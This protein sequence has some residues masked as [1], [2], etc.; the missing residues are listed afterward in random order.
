MLLKKGEV[1][2]V[3]SGIFESYSREGPFVATQD[4]DLDTFVA[5]AVSAVT[6]AWE[7]TGVLWEVPRMLVVQGFL[8]ELPCRRIHLGALGDVELTEGKKDL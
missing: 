7:V 5:K 8:A 2:T 4:F 1:V 3:V 6:E